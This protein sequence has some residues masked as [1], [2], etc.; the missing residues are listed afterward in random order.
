MVELIIVC[1]LMGAGKT[2][3]A[4]EY[5]EKFNYEYIDFDKEYHV[6][7]QEE[8]DIYKA[9]E[10][11]DRLATRLNNCENGNFICDSWF[12]WIKDWWK[13]SDDITLSELQKRL[14][15][16]EIRVIHLTIPC[17]EAYKRYLEKHKEDNTIQV[18]YE[19]TIHLREVN[20]NNKILQ[21]AIQ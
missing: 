4:K 10:F 1:G 13:N 5:A 11:I 14:K 17:K 15:H 21:W 12:C 18:D 19:M 3:F 8:Q 7:I 2:T 20:I 16:H 9:Y 6:K